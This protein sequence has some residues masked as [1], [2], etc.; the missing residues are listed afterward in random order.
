MPEFAEF[1]KQLA[2]LNRQYTA[3][4][5]DTLAQL[6]RDAGK[7]GP[8][9][10]RTDLEDFH[11]RLH[12]LA[13]SGGT[14]GF[15]E[16]SRRARA[17]EVACKAW[18]DAPSPAVAPQWAAWLAGVAALGDTLSTPDASVVVMPEAQPP[19]RDKLEHVRLVVIEDE[20]E[21]GRA[22][23]R[24]LSQF[25]YDVA[26]FA[27]FQ[28]ARQ[29]VLA[30]PPQ[31]LVVDIM[32]PGSI[33]D[34]GTAAIP[35]LF[36][37]LGY[38]LP[39]IFLTARTDFRARLAVARAGGEAFLTKPVDVPGLANRIEAML[40]ERAQSPFRVLVVD[41]DE[42][43]AEHYKL[44]LASA[45]MMADRVCT[46]DEV[47]AAIETLCPDLILMD[48]YM[49][50]CTGAE[51]ARTIRYNDAWQSMP[52][53]FLSSENDI[54]TQSLALGSGAD[55]FLTKPILD[56]RL[57]S[58]VRARAT[59]ARKVAELMSQDSLTGLLKHASIKDRLVQELGRA[60]RQ[61]HPLALAMLDIDRF[62]HVNDTWGHP[63]GD[64]VIKSLGHL[65]RQRLRRQDSIGRYGGEEFV[66]ILPES[67]YAAA[68]NLIEDIRQRFNEVRFVHNGETFSVSLSAGVS[69]STQFSDVATLLAAAD[70]AL[71]S[72]KRAG[73]NQVKLASEGL[74]VLV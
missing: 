52:I 3:Q 13:G 65:L 55:D 25:G 16:L 73:R 59:R 8:Q 67:N 51:L 33:P 56:G 4:L 40:R 43:L 50:E 42:Q 37:E 45:G 47:Y 61:G 66:A 1:A 60:Q 44:A 70:A 34:D 64:H 58:A 12:K 71:Y 9:A 5:G 22:L 27:D 63:M 31:L 39:A 54:E 30:S 11:R 19:Q 29:S 26:L 35:L 10:S 28:S 74:E 2:Q 41:D 32:L 49:P 57:V 38:P 7:A 53:V 18:L 68:R 15:T 46:A 36:Q 6:A 23:Q 24:G 20:P 69:C 72:A 62:K 14:F 48:L 21:T 17:L